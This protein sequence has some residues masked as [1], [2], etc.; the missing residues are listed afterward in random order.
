MWAPGIDGGA[1]EFDGSSYVDTGYTEDLATYTIACWAKS[2]DAPSGGA[3]SGPLHREQNYQFN[4]NHGNEVFRGAA[5]MNAAGAWQ[6][7]S[8]MPLNADTWYHLAA[9]Y[10]GTDFKGYRDGVLITTTPVSGPPNAESNTAKLARHAAAAQF[11]TGT[12]DDARIYNRALTAEEIQKVMR[13]DPLVAWDPSPANNSTPNVKDAVPLTWSPG[14]NAAQHD[15]YFGTDMDAVDDA[16]ASDTT[17]VY[18]GRQSA[19]T[20]TPTEALEWGTG[21]YYWRIDEINTDGTISEGR[22]WNFTVADFILVE[23]FESY[24][25]DDPAGEAIW[26]HW[27]DG[28]NVPTNGSQSGYPLPPY[29]EQSIVHAGSQS[30]PFHYDNTGGVTNS[31]AELKLTDARDWTE[32]G[33]GELSIRFHGRAASVG[34]FVEGPVGTFTMTGSGTDIWNVGTA[35]DYRD[36]FHFAYKTLTGAGTIIARVNSVENTNGWAKAGVMIRETLEPGSTHAFGCVTPSNGVASQGRLETGGDSFN[37][38]EGGITAPHWVKLERDVAGNFTVSHSTNGS[39]WVPVQGSVPQNIQMA[40]TVY[41]GLALTSH[42]AGA[43]C[44]AVFSNVTIT[45]QVGPQW[46]NQDIGIASNAAEPLYVAISNAAGAPAVLAHPDAGA[47]NIETWTEWV[48]PLSEFSDKGINLSDVDKI[49]IGLGAKGGAASGGSGL[50]FIDDI[51][52]YRPRNGA[53]Q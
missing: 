49:A 5:A 52:L 18:R 38:A 23:D 12:V 35:G 33:V 27:I 7:A 45:G 53:G 19:T 46:M 29:A 44:E 26:Q 31:E 20:F 24:T 14:D 37:A 25:D 22:L 15:V 39:T 11:F 8:Y 43:T 21:P 9:T 4:W 34:S 42:S 28:F 32:Q 40:S 36:E 51:R 41:I 48:I 17:G 3:A 2:P 1:L 50:V 6:A 10:D 13:G 47:A 16:D 30:M